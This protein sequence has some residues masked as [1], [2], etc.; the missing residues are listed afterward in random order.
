MNKKLICYIL[1]FTITLLTIQ[2]ISFSAGDEILLMKPDKTGG[3]P[4]MAALNKRKS[5]RSFSENPLSD[6]VLSNILWAA[7][8]VNRP[9]S[10]KRTA[11]TAMNNQEIEIYAAMKSGLYKYN[12][13][14]HSLEL[15]LGKDIRA[16]A[17]SQEF[18]KD[19][20]LNLIY[21]ADISKVAGGTR[22]EKMLYAG[23]DTGFI[24]ENVYLYCASEGLATVIRGYIEKNAL[25]NAMKLNKNQ[26]IILSQTVGYPGK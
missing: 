11:P 15:I 4:I 18:V 22:E 10:G 5:S 9:D 12:A 24:G 23:A 25:G 3:I 26:M 6:Q 16:L 2:K 19:A 7:S 21:V 20:P 14:K 8:G 17:G 13:V 1:S